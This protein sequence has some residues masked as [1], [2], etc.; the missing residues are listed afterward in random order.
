MSTTNT[1]VVVTG[2]G[3]SV[4]QP[5]IQEVP[6]SYTALSWFVCL[7]CCWPIGIAAIIASSKVSFIYNSLHDVSKTSIL[8]RFNKDYARTKQIRLLNLIRLEG[9][10]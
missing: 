1:T 5:Q 2:G 4:A 3:Q 8:L 7:L 6:P 10:Y 9:L